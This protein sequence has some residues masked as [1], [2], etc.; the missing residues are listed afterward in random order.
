MSLIITSN[1]AKSD[2][3]QFSTTGIN[4]P[5]SYINNLQGTFKIPKNAQ[6]AVQS[7]KINKSGNIAISPNN[8]RFGFYFGALRD[9]NPDAENVVGL[10]SILQVHTASFPFTNTFQD[11]LVDRNMNPEKIADLMTIAGNRNLFSPLLLANAS[12]ALNEG[13]KCEVLRNAS[14]VDFLGYKMTQDIFSASNNASFIS[15]NWINTDPDNRDSLP[16]LT[17]GGGGVDVANGTGIDCEYLGTDY[18]MSVANGSFIVNLN[19]NNAS[20]EWVIGL[21]RNQRSKINGVR[22]DDFVRPPYYDAASEDV[23][24][25]YFDWC[26]AA[27]KSGTDFEI[28]IYETLQLNAGKAQAGNTTIQ[29]EYPYVD[30]P[31]GGGTNPSTPY[32]V[33]ANK[34]TEVSFEIKNEQIFVRIN[35]SGV[36]TTIVDGTKIYG[37]NPSQTLHPTSMATRFIYPK[38]FV[39]AGKELKIT[40]FNGINIKDFIYGDV[41]GGLD[42]LNP[43]NNNYMDLYAT[44]MNLGLTQQIFGEPFELDRFQFINTGVD[45]FGDAI[46]LRGMNSTTANLVDYNFVMIFEPDDE[47][48]DYDDLY[49]APNTQEVFGFSQ[50]PVI[51]PVS[52]VATGAK[53]FR[54]V[55]QSSYVPELKSVESIFVR[56]R[57]MTFESVNIA[58][59]AMSKILYH[60]P[61]FT[62]G[63]EKSV[64]SL[65]FEPNERVYVDLNNSQ[66]QQIS[67]MEVEFVR[68]DETIADNLVGKSVVVFHIKEK[69]N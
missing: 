15:T 65:F 27:K 58:K 69:G 25:G 18:P 13:Y 4:T 35:A 5:S 56:L 33:K 7:V 2:A 23:G 54:K 30:K 3:S 21:T 37:A 14:S 22:S 32:K 40:T 45:A 38:L 47:Y 49:G 6:I 50:S 57:N 1:T 8:S 17:R 44:S 68:S 55:F 66:E 63:T 43:S 12:T 9:D 29:V 62:Q 19:G 11:N 31:V 46:N 20:S 64:G 10:N 67:T 28:K 61:E 34:V 24:G 53:A 26:V 39:P 36:L 41:A 59:G 52:T 16:T 42:P 51:T 60:L 48:N